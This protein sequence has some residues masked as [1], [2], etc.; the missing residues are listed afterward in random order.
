MKGRLEY[1]L[2][3]SIGSLGCDLSDLLEYTPDKE[4]TMWQDYVER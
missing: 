4:R 1:R 3:I 2:N